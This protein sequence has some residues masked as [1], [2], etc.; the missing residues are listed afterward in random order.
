MSALFSEIKRFSNAI[1][2]C[3]SSDSLSFETNFTRNV[4]IV[5]TKYGVRA[6]AVTHFTNLKKIH[7]ELYLGFR[8]VN[9][10]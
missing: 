9:K 3:S 1:V 8:I 6:I 10:Y 2:Q 4:E 7:K 5:A